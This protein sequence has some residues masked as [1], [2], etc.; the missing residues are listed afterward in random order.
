MGK[1]L[2]DPVIGGLENE[3]ITGECPTSFGPIISKPMPVPTM[4]PGQCC[5]AH[6]AAY[7]RCSLTLCREPSV[8]EY[9]SE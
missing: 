5:A 3:D 9:P 6:S 7:R 1:F 4:P 8:G 2:V